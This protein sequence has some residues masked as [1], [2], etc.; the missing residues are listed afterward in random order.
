MRR[1]VKV[2][3]SKRALSGLD[4]DVQEGEAFGLLGPNGAGK[5]TAMSV[6]A[7]LLPLDE[8]S[9]VLFGDRAPTDPDARAL[10]GFAPQELALY[11]HLTARENLAFFGRL[12]GISREALPASI[13]RALV[14]AGLSE[15][16]GDRVSSFSG[17][18]QR[19]LNLASALVHDPKLLLL[20]EPTAGVDPQSRAHLFACLERLRDDGLTIVYS[21]HYME[22]VERLCS[23]VAIIDAGQVVAAG[24]VPEVTSQHGGEATVVVAGPNLETAFLKLTGRSLRDHG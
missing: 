8:G 14:L 21:S 19:R 3:G 11:P 16:A 1:A 23:R 24:S 10:V 13:E 5:T 9:V 20:D 6:M 7:G 18:M 15:R 12:Y 4:L 17:G 2:F 22:E